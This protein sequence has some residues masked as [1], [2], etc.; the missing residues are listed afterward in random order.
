[1]ARMRVVTFHL[2]LNPNEA[3]DSTLENL[4]M[5]SLNLPEH[6]MLDALQFLYKFW[7]RAKIL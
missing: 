7:V 6:L 1:M 3:I 2:N 5:E 4:Y